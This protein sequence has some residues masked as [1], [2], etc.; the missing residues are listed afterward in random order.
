MGE[1]PQP[2]FGLALILK[3]VSSIDLCFEEMLDPF[4]TGREFTA[5]VSNRFFRQAYV[6]IC[7][8]LCVFVYKAKLVNLFA[9][10]LVLSSQVSSFTRL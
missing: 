4:S 1:K 2:I 3:Y 8:L 9:I 5:L 7:L 10:L 6:K